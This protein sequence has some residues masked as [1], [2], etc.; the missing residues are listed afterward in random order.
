MMRKAEALRVYGIQSKDESLQKMA[1]RIRARAM[2]R[3]GEILSEVEPSKG[4][5][6]THDGGGTSRSKAARDAGLSPRQKVTAL[7]I[8]NV[9]EAQFEAAVESENPPSVRRLADLLLSE[10]TV[11][12]YRP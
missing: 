5:Q 4:G 6:P 12:S 10:N 9:P 8:A 2:R 1:A 3:A 7:R 11:R